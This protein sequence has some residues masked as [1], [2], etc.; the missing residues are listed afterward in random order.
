MRFIGGCTQIMPLRNVRAQCNLLY[1]LSITRSI[2]NFHGYLIRS[3]IR[4]F[5][6][7][8]IFYI[9]RISREM[10]PRIVSST[11][12]EISNKIISNR[13]FVSTFVVAT[14]LVEYI[15]STSSSSIV[16]EET[17]SNYFRF[18]SLPNLDW[19]LNVDT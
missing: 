12:I 7:I 18:F 19:F 15:F 10:F 6:C 9:F 11:P 2:D 1:N 5:T 13:V 4:T 14:C 16:G 17:V 3:H 8:R